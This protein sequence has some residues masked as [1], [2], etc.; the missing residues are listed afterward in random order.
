M[1]ESKKKGKIREEESESTHTVTLLV[2]DLIEGK[3]PGR[4]AITKE[5][6]SMLARILS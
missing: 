4:I 2:L 1:N 6:I 5:R 3:Y